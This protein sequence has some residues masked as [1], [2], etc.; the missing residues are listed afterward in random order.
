MFQSHHLLQGRGRVGHRYAGYRH[1][2]KSA[3]LPAMTPLE[4]S[5]FAAAARNSFGAT[6]RASEYI[7]S[8]AN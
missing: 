8:K 6:K 3:V 5:R 7:I 1:R 4:Q 2:P